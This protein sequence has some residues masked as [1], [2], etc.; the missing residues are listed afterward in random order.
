MGIEHELRRLLSLPRERQVAAARQLIASLPPDPTD[1][2]WNT[3]FGPDTLFDA[4]TRTTVAG[5]ARGA[6]AAAVRPVLDARPGWRAIEVGA[7]NGALWRQVL[8]PSDQGELVVVDPVPEAIDRVA[9]LVPPGVRV[10]PLPGLVQD[11][12]LPDAD[13]VVCSL[14][15]HHVAG[16]DAAER[17]RHGLQG[18]GKVEVLAAFGRALAARDGLGLLVEAD[19]DCDLDLAPGDPRLA[20]NLLDSYVRRC[21]RAMIADLSSAD[22]E[23]AARLR[24]MLRRWFLEQILVADLPVAERDVYELTVPRWLALLDRAGLRVVQHAF[25]DDLPLF[26]L[27]CFRSSQRVSNTSSSSATPN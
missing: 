15:L 27:Y 7:G 26:Q 10:T 2:A 9:A 17:A 8:R 5:Q 19:V 22:P 20:D 23:L 4:W 14:T 16:A 18:P 13:L 12:A 1:E 24:V 3:R 21:A 25:T 11:V 6:T